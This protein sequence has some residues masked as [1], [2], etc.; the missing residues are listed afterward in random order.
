MNNTQ[1]R[2]L[3]NKYSCA[4]A[5]GDIEHN[6]FQDIIKNANCIGDTAE[7]NENIASD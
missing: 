7:F 2:I 4:F 3:L 6:K 5:V 1:V